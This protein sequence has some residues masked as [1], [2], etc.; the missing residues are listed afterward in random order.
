MGRVINP[1]SAGKQR[2]QLIRSV[3]LALRELVKKPDVDDE[4]R[5]LAAYIALAL[6][7]VYRTID[8]SV[9]AWE[10]RGYWVKADRFRMDWIWTESLGIALQNAL[11]LN[12]WPSVAMISA[13]IMQKL[14]NVKVPQ[15]HR[16]GT[17]WVGA[18]E[19]LQSG[20]QSQ[21]K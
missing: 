17:P 13:Q 11:V 18:W 1:E 3:V 20:M 5:D 14:K 19:R 6:A 2:T 16:L 10:K 4:T 21:A 15:R 9:S 12:D 8:I 7:S